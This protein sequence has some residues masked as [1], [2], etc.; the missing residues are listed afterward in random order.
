MGKEWTQSNMGVASEDDFILGRIKNYGRAAEGTLLPPPQVGEFRIPLVTR[1][2]IAKRE[3]YMGGTQFTLVWMSVE[4]NDSALA[5]SHYQV[6]VRSLGTN[7]S[8]VAMSPVTI[9]NSPAVI[10]V[11]SKS[12]TRVVFT[13]QTVLTNGQISDFETS[14]TT[15]GTTIAGGIV[16]ADIPSGT[17]TPSQIANGT[18]GQLI[19]WSSTGVATTVGPGT[20]NQLVVSQGAGQVPTYR[21]LSSNFT[22]ATK[23]TS[24]TASTDLLVYLCD[25]TGGAIVATLPAATANQLYILKKIDTTANLVT[26]TPNGVET[27]DGAATY[28]ISTPYLALTLIGKASTGWFIL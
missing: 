18:A 6:N 24:F 27:I 26:L 12:A 28:A 5:V 13:V 20:T 16:T 17:V 8:K 2:S 22:A 9:D 15:A 14:P 25:A 7:T 10:R 23:S 3:T 11:D 21:F 1:L 19:T 4:A